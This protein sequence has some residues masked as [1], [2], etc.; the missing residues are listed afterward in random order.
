MKNEKK[1]INDW[2]SQ[3]ELEDFKKDLKKLNN[4]SFKLY[5]QAMREEYARR[6]KKSSQMRKH[7]NQTQKT[8]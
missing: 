6:I 2:M 5:V 7:Y 4:K 8:K 3:I 1:I